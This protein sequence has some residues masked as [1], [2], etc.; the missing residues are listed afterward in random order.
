MTVYL[1]NSA[2]TPVCPEA[3]EKMAFI[4][5][6]CYGNPSSTHQMGRAAK[7]VMDEARD[8]VA[9]ALGCAPDELYFTSGGTE[10]DNLAVFGACE[11]LRHDGRHIITTAYEHD[12]VLK[13]FERLRDR[14][15]EVTFLK[16]DKNGTVSAEEFEKALRPDTVFASV[17]LVNNETGAVNDVSKMAKILKTNNS[18]ALFHTDAVQA[19]CKIDTSPRVTG[20]DLISISGHKIHGPKGVGALYIRKGVK[21]DPM[22][23]GGGQE[24]GMRSG[25]EGLYG[26]AGFGEAAKIGKER[27]KESA[28]LFRQLRAG[29]V[30][31]VRSFSDD[32]V[33]I[34][35]GAD[36]ILCVSFPGYRSEVLLNYL[37]AKGICVSKGSACKRGARSHVL[38]AMGLDSRVIDGALRFSFSRYN[39]MEEI[40]YTV[41]ILKEATGR[42]IKVQEKR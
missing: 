22:T 41:Q 29:L 5:K 19:F 11:R 27:M 28:E 7:K 4:M 34:G 36:H 8:N 9:R 30:D 39:T 16:P 2:T 31:G 24:R 3:A 18:R 35:G 38:T 33:V 12:A 10:A 23:L 14:G 15:W 21:I 17:M 6:N 26:I 1:D 13:P 25:T 42:L 20:A 40:D 32:A 37:D